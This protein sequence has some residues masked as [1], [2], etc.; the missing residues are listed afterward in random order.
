MGGQCFQLGGDQDEVDIK[1]N[2]NL[3]ISFSILSKGSFIGYVTNIIA[4]R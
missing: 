1:G 4:W 2:S 3:I